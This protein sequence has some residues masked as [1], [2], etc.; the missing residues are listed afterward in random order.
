[1]AGD[2]PAAG[3]DA[4]DQ[5]Q[6]V[7]PGGARRDRAGAGRRPRR[8]AGAAGGGERRLLPR[9]APAA[10]PGRAGAR[11]YRAAADGGGAQPAGGGRGAGAGA[12]A[13]CGDV[14][15]RAVPA[16]HWLR[17]L[18]H[19]ERGALRPLACGGGADDGPRPGLRLQPARYPA[20]G[21]PVRLG[22]GG[23]WV[24]GRLCALGRADART[25]G[26]VVGLGA[27]RPAG[28]AG[29]D[30]AAGD[31][32]RRPARAAHRL[33]D[34]GAAAGAGDAPSRL[35]GHGDGAGGL[36]RAL[37][38]GGARAGAGAAR[39]G[40]RG[41]GGGAGARPALRRA[42]GAVA[43]HAEMA[44]RGDGGRG[45]ARAAGARPLAAGAAAGGGGSAGAALPAELL[46]GGGGGAGAV[47]VPRPS[48]RARRDNGEPGADAGQRG[49]AGGDR[50]GGR[51]RA[52]RDGLARRLRHPGRSL[53]PGPRRL[54]D[55]RRL[56]APPL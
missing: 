43:E 26:A 7:P 31:A 36:G 11:P 12:G 42:A 50:L 49:A 13:G 55:R 56:T 14:P 5:R 19:G 52:G 23:A 40:A 48:R 8:R 17:G 39:G 35:C 45:G 53:G 47:A 34:A 4:G 3:A 29:A 33:E 38:L 41:D 6:P 46:S 9:P 25:G 15:G 2:A 28:P 1:E 30:A 54:P 44:G 18:L 37:S 21:R 22:G 16:R 51:R 32:G 10:D 20:G 27:R 24:A